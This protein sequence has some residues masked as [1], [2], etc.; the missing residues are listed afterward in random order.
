MNRDR[1]VSN[2]PNSRVGCSPASTVH[3]CCW[4]LLVSSL[5]KTEKNPA[6]FSNFSKPLTL[7]TFLLIYGFTIFILIF[8]PIFHTPKNTKMKGTAWRSKSQVSTTNEAATIVNEATAST[9]PHAKLPSD[10]TRELVLGLKAPFSTPA[11]GQVTESVSSKEMTALKQPRGRKK[12]RKRSRTIWADNTTPKP[13]TK[14]IK[15]RYHEKQKHGLC[16]VHSIN[17]AIGEKILKRADVDREVASLHCS[18]PS[19]PKHGGSKG[20]YT[21]TALQQAC[22][23]KGYLLRKLGGKS[24]MWLGTQ[25]YGKFIMMGCHKKYDERKFHYVAVDADQGVIVDSARKG[26]LA[27]N[28]YGVLGV[29][30]C[31]I[32]KLYRIEKI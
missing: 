16:G 18:N 22:Q 20:F 19:G 6:F 10:L 8:F 2:I 9:T 15:G 5:L 30:S 11:S 4:F 29:L 1:R 14:K 13:K 25:K 3:L 17:N 28:W 32:H 27:L 24:H 7:I 12:K 31:G 23:K 21:I 26:M